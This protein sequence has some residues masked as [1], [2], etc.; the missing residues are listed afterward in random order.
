[1]PKISK[2]KAASSKSINLHEHP[3][4]HDPDETPLQ[5]LV[6]VPQEVVREAYF[7]LVYG[8]KP[9]FFKFFDKL[10][11]TI[12]SSIKL[13]AA[14]I[15]FLVVYWMPLGLDYH[16]QAALAIFAGI[17]LLWT[18]EAIPM[19]VTALLVPVLLTAFGIFG[20]SDALLPFAHPVVYLILGGVILAAAVHKTGM[21]K[22]MLYPF[23]IRSGGKPDRLL[24]YMMLVSAILSMWIS[25]TA[26]DTSFTNCF[27]PDPGRV[28]TVD[29]SKDG[30]GC[31]DRSWNS[32][33]P[34]DRISPSP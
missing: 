10:S 29:H 7:H 23:L 34:S 19:P 24:L 1:M 18:T 16:A 8:V 21:D 33:W 12:R 9:P 22:R 11:H 28:D 3:I 4:I 5:H 31:C 14:L 13:L 15:G 26:T 17:A 2:K 32:S 25:N 30:R 27:R 20:T 6:H